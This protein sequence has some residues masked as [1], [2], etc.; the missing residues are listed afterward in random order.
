[1]RVFWGPRP[2]PGCGRREKEPGGTSAPT[3]GSQQLGARSLPPVRPGPAPSHSY[4]EPVPVVVA[5]VSSAR[6]RVTR[7]DTA[8]Q[9]WVTEVIPGEAEAPLPSRSPQNL[10][11]PR[12]PSGERAPPCI[13]G[14]QP[15]HPDCALPGHPDHVL[16]PLLRGREAEVIIN[17]RRHPALGPGSTG[18]AGKPACGGEC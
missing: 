13:Q 4:L 15:W 8:R 16:L 3:R 10:C 17:L 7:G 5:A 11:P 12:S 6:A 9:P 14:K 1:M 18:G 2:Q